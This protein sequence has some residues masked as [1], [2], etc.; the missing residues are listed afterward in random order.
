MSSVAAPLMIS[1]LGSSSSLIS[2]ADSCSKL[3]AFVCFKLE[4]SWKKNILFDELPVTVLIRL[5]KGITF[6]V[7]NCYGQSK[8]LKRDVSEG[9]FPCVFNRLLSK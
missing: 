9:L 8:G 7:E 3:S 4:I 5:A 2:K 1:L 6:G